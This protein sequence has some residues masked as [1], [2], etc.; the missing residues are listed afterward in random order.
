MWSIH[1][2]AGRLIEVK[3]VSPVTLQE[4]Q[5]FAQRLR[6]VSDELPERF[7]GCVHLVEANI[8]PPDV[9]NGF[10]NIMQRDNPRLERSAFLIGAQAVFALQIERMLREADHSRRR[11]FRSAETLAEW[12]SEVLTEEEK[13]ALHRFLGM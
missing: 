10:I 13:A 7:V 2:N 8:F 4:L 9:A 5:P 11:S 1:R 6:E 12:L 3:V